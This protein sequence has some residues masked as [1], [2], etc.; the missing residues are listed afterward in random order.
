YAQRRSP[1]RT[2]V[3]HRRARACRDCTMTPAGPIS[4]SARVSASARRNVGQST[5][6]SQ[7]FTIVLRTA[8]STFPAWRA[9]GA[10]NRAN[11]RTTAC[12]AGQA[13]AHGESMLDAFKNMTGGK[14]KLTQQQTDDLEVLIATAKEERSAISAMLTSL[15][16]RTA[17]L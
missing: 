7:A 17:K 4:S 16:T 6:G 5:P 11:S 14:G 13:P 3:G 12:R 2:S 8:S 9:H 10:E 15:T 1:E